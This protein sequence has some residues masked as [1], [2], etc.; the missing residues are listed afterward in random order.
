MDVVLQSIHELPQ[1]FLDGWNG[2]LNF[3]LSE[4]YRN[5]K[6]IVVSG[7]G[8]SR[9]P[10]LIISELFKTE[11]TV[12]LIINNEYRMPGF[13]DADTLFIGSSY[14]GTTEETIE[15]TKQAKEK[16]AKVVGVCVGGELKKYLDDNSLP[17]FVFDPKHN[18][19]GQPRMGFGYNFGGIL[20]ILFSLGFIKIEKEKT[21]NAFG[22]V[23][24]M[25]KNLEQPAKEMA[26]E[27]FNKY[28][29]VVTSEFL[30]GCGNA[31]ANQINETAKA[32]SNLRLIPELNHH[33]MEGLKH[34]SEFKDLDVFVLFFSKLY[35]ERI[36]KRFLITKEV[37]EQ[38]G[39]KTVWYELQGKDSIQQVLEFL[40]FSSLMT[41]YL[42]EMYGEDPTAIPFVDFFKK[43]LQE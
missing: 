4:D 13:V 31:M 5:V 41:M 37:V 15:N 28:A 21:E 23:F 19:S 40:V 25:T 16:G 22:Q 30:G 9:F 10:T 14:S 42:S 24:E 43:R 20:G 1:Q 32:N 35:S 6:N 3:K 2:A 33:L 18:P 11:L 17:C 34:P 27:L 8:G 38:N 29:T 39:L 7:M 26:S 36:Q 12:P